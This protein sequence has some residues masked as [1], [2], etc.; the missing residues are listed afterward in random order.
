MFKG[1]S[2]YSL[3]KD[4]L[5]KLWYIHT[6][7]YSAAIK[8]ILHT[9]SHICKERVPRCII[10]WKTQST[11]QYVRMWSFV[12]KKWINIHLHL[13]FYTTKNTYMYTHNPSHTHSCKY[14]ITLEGCIRN[15]ICSQEGLSDKEKR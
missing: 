11:E 15:I 3:I 12:N 9:T 4:W 1:I 7:E 13:H 14:E 6:T 8:G 5:N 10:K 2:K